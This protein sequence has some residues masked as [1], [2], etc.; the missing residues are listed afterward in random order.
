MRFIDAFPIGSISTSLQPFYEDH[1][2]SY[3]FRT[4]YR[5][6]TS[7]TIYAYEAFEIISKL[8]NDPRFH[9]RESLRNALQNLEG[10]PVLTGSVSSRQNGEL[11][12][13][14]NIMRIRAKKTV[15]LF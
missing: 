10:F 2:Q 12:K 8:L 9:N 7:Y 14:L 6:P 15:A 13:K 4:D 1:W 3:N 11:I 5:T